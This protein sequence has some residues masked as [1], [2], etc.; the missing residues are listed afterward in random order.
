V[1]RVFGWL[2]LGA[3]TAGA[4]TVQRVEIVGA[5]ADRSDAES[6][7]PLTV[8]RAA[9]LARAGVTT[10][11]QALAL[12]AANQAADGMAQAV[13]EATGGIAEAD[14]RGFGPENTLVLLNGRRIANHAY[15]AGTADL[16]AIPLA[17]I[18]RIEVRRD[19]AS[20]LHGSG[21]VAGVIDFILRDD[22]HGLEVAL[23]GELPQHPGGAVARATLAGG[24]GQLARDGFNAFVVLDLRQQAAIAA[25]DRRFAA[26]GIRRAADGSLL[27]ARLSESSFPG[28][29]DG[30]EPSLTA[31]CA[32]PRSVPDPDAPGACGY[33]TAADV[34]LVPANR[35]ALLL[36]RGLIALGP[37]QQLTLEG[38][39]AQNE[40]RARI[41]PTPFTQVLPESSPYWIAGRPV[42][43][44][45]DYGPGGIVDWRAVPAGRRS[46]ASR[47]G[48]LR[49]LAAL[50]GEAGAGFDYSLAL[51]RAASRARD[52][53]IA[54]HLDAALVQQALVDGR[55]DPFAAPDATGAAALQAA[56][57]RGTTARARG[58]TSS[59]DLRIGGPRTGPLVASAGLEWRHEAFD[60]DL[61]PA[62]ERVADA[63]FDLAQDTAGRRRAVAVFG[64]LE[65]RP[66]P[67][68]RVELALRHERTSDAAALTSPLA[69]VRWQALPELVLRGSAGRS[70]RLPT[71]YETREPLRLARTGDEFDD[72]LLCPGGEPADGVDPDRA[73]G[74]DLLQRTG[75]PVAYGRPPAT[76]APESGRHATLGAVL[77]PTHRLSLGLDLWW[78]RLAGRIDA[79][80]PEQVIDDP[81]LHAGHIVRCRD[82]GAAAAQIVDCVGHES[83]DLIAFLD[84]P[85]VNLG[86]IESRG[87][88]LSLSWHG[89]P[90]PAGAFSVSFNGSYIAHHRREL[91]RA[92][93]YQETAGRYAD[94]QALPRWQHAW[95]A[96]WSQGPWSVTLA[97]RWIAGYR[98]ARGGRRVGSYGL[99]DL[100]LAWEPDARTTI[101]LGLHN[102]LDREPP[103]T[104]QR[105]TPQA[106]HD[107][108]LT[109]PQGRTLGIRVRHRIR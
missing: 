46:S 75:G 10:A 60:F 54:G 80:A 93:V 59:L 3:A 17:A 78:L 14:L 53:L 58:D 103:F 20:A 68:L 85:L 104:N 13:G 81:L 18:D 47:S 71:L 55:L 27:Q 22:L 41:A 92:G 69:A 101:E 28:D 63:G 61:Q 79:L 84:T 16:N 6:A 8:W 82:L 86:R 24:T 39:V 52:R 29:L 49:L 62:A 21:A 30:F 32:P 19:G 57:V 107:P 11:R 77:T 106:N 67:A 83:S 70:F 88:D 45:E 89:E 87:V 38:L 96:G 102:L 12:V 25:A 74:R 26:S 95:Q 72:P 73:C 5:R 42:E 76:L 90:M 91:D 66:A 4:Q 35:Q 44:I 2:L 97:Q 7:A 64:Q 1:N 99:L 51:V 105:D 98:D 23:Q 43:E 100:G 108:R 31:G 33:D 94:D 56:A 37:R 15:E 50:D 65:W 109:D 48:Q 40:V 34:D 9:D 36:A